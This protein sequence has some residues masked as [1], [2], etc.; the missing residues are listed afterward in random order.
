MPANLSLV[1]DEPEKEDKPGVKPGRNA[2]SFRLA[3]F[4]KKQI[5]QVDKANSRWHKRGNTVLRR[6]RDERNKLAEEGQR[7]MNI[8]WANYKVMKPA[9]YSRLPIPVIDRN[10]LDHDPVG[11]LSSQILER[12]VKN[13]AKN[14]Y[15]DAVNGAV[16]DR[17]LPGRGIVWPR[18]EPEFGES[19]SLPSMNPVGLEDELERIGDEVGDSSFGKETEEEE[20]LEETGETVIAEK[21]IFDYV[22]WKDFYMF[23]AK[24]RRWEEA[25]GIAKRVYISKKEAKKRFGKEIGSAMQPDTTLLEDTSNRSTGYSDAAIFRDI[26]ERQ[27]VVFEIWNK[28]DRRVYWVSQ[29]YEYLCDV[30]DDPLELKKFFPVPKPLCSTTTNDSVIPVPDYWEWQDQAIQIDEIT[31]RLANLTKAC[32]VAGVYNAAN[33][34]ISR[35]FNESVENKLIPEEQWAAFA[36]QG[37]LKGAIDFIPIDQIQA[38]IETLQK[39]KQDQMIDLDQITG[40][41]DVLR[42][43]TDSR[44][45]L[46]GI[47]IKNNNAGTRLSEAQQEVAEFCRELI[48]IACEIMCKHFDDQTLIEAS[49]ILFE[50]ALQP[51]V[52]QEE[53]QLALMHQQAQQATQQPQPQQP[54]QSAPGL[55]PGQQGPPQQAPSNVLPFPQ[56]GQQPNAQ[57]GQQQGPPQQP[58][59]QSQQLQPPSIDPQILVMMKVQ[60]AISLLRKDVVRDYRIEIEVDSTIFGDKQQEREDANEFI[61]A[62]GQFMGNFETVATAVPEAVPFLGKLLQWGVRKSRTGRDLEAEIDNLVAKLEMKT[63]QAAAAGPQP[64]PEV[65]KQQMEIQKE[66]MKMQAQK[67]NDQRDAARQQAEDQRNAQLEG[68]KH[69]METQRMQQEHEL[70][71]QRMAMEMEKMQQEM[72]LAREKHQMEI[73]KMQMGLHVKQQEADTKLHLAHQ[74]GQLEQQQMHQ[75]AAHDQQQMHMEGQHAQQQMHMKHQEAQQSHELKMQH[76][77]ANAAHKKSQIGKPKK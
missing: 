74:E 70:E 35:I 1:S 4:W 71:Q 40:L 33:N 12:A 31:T 63:K 50:E 57:A 15:H 38:A 55:P 56:Q 11:R 76:D 17:L 64:N 45:T 65:Q 73:Q 13:E 14:G 34:A 41:S 24:T 68:S 28:T 27:I 36:Q 69:Q 19:P 75:Q 61:A 52:V 20:K 37:G 23:P 2:E 49:G 22:D 21:V 9:I 7:K 43:T 51:D 48:A 39:V 60:Q 77:K 25:Q 58:Q 6:F 16:M 67:E 29:G 5:D 10:F 30:Q 53:Y 26:N 42:G 32:K 66:Q 3:A 62:V 54:P 18:Y 47:R 46:G 59:P 8:L 44:E 72:Q